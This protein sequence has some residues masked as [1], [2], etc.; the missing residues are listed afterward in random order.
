MRERVCRLVCW[1]EPGTTLNAIW[2]AAWLSA[3]MWMC[4]TLFPVA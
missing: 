1:D 3:N 2:T 4:V